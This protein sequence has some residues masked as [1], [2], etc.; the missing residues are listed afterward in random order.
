M[1]SRDITMHPFCFKH[2]RH[3]LK[4]SAA[5]ESVTGPLLIPL[6]TEVGVLVINSRLSILRQGCVLLTLFSPKHV[7]E[8]VLSFSKANLFE[9]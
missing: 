7:D 5:S 2:R 1:G 3:Q 8:A 6:I 9:N 4:S